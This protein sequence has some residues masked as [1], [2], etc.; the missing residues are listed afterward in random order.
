M[1]Y[2]GTN[3]HFFQCERRTVFVS[4]FLVSCLSVA[5][6]R[7]LASVKDATA[8]ANNWWLGRDEWEVAV[9]QSQV[10]S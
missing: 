2:Y 5:E 3:F 4:S 9:G 10:E 6:P 1:V 7:L 8:V